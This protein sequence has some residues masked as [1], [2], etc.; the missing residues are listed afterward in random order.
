MRLR[1]VWSFSI[2]RLRDFS[3]GMKE[4]GWQ[5]SETFWDWVF[6]SLLQRGAVL[7]HIG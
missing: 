3:C 4:G 2:D 1:S 7:K 6:A 5:A